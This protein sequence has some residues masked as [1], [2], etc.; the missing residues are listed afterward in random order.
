MW[1]RMQAEAEEKKKGYACVVYSSRKITKADLF[2]LEQQSFTSK[3]G[4][5]ADCLIVSNPIPL[6]S[7]STLI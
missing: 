5:G 7:T 4:E 6:L 3:D 1:E 2:H